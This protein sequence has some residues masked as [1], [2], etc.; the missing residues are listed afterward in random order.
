MSSEC[1]VLTET[2]TRGCAAVNRSKMAG[3]ALIDLRN[4]YTPEEVI[5]AGFEWQG[6]GKP[7]LAKAHAPE[8]A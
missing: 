1:P 2:A 8:A 6:I 5:A 7:G 4:V 3:N